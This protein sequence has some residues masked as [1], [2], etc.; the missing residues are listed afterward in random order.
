MYVRT[1]PGVTDF[2]YT[3][4]RCV[5]ERLSGHAYPILYLMRYAIKLRPGL[6]L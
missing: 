4:V 1:P 3:C 5:T 2:I 6:K